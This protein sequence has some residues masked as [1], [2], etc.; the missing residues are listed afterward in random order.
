MRLAS[1]ATRRKL[2]LAIIGLHM[3]SV[4]ADAVDVPRGVDDVWDLED[5][6]AFLAIRG[7]PDKETLRPRV[8]GKEHAVGKEAREYIPRTRNKRAVYPHDA[9]KLLGVD[10]GEGLAVD[11]GLRREEDGVT[12]VVDVAEEVYDRPQKNTNHEK[13]DAFPRCKKLWLDIRRG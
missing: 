4:C 9:I 3:S 8:G 6:I 10:G 7:V 2:Y 13:V 5:T 11:I 1:V 12:G